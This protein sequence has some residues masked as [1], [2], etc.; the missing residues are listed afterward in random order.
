MQAKMHRNVTDEQHPNGLI[1]HWYV[2]CVTV[3]TDFANEWR[4]VDVV[5]VTANLCKVQI[6]DMTLQWCEIM[7]ALL[8]VI[9]YRGI[10]RLF[11]RGA[12]EWFFARDHQ[13]VQSGQQH[14]CWL[15]LYCKCDGAMH[16]CNIAS[17]LHDAIDRG[18]LNITM[19][20]CS[21]SASPQHC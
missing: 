11:T 5:E 9:S 19:M 7:N 15:P 1:C 21:I 16:F 12:A 2:K 17:G 10:P 6:P 20:V 4:S 3:G 14:G 18:L 8:A 13:A